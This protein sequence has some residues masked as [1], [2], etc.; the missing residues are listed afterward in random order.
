MVG[1]IAENIAHVIS[2]FVI[3][4]AFHSPTLG[5][6]AV[7]S[8]WVP[9]LLFS[10]YSGGFA[11]RFDC[12]KLSSSRRRSSCW[13]PCRGPP[14]RDAQSRKEVYDSVNRCPSLFRRPHSDGVRYR[15]RCRAQKHGDVIS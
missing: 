4:Q 5:G 6:F 3:Y 7:I 10:V 13:R 2:Y 9:Y 1:L 8:H 15:F 11:D 14:C 12:R